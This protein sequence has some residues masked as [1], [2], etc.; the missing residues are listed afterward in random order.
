MGWLFGWMGR[1]LR[2]ILAMTSLALLLALIAL[3]GWAASLEDAASST[4]GPVQRAFRQ[5]GEP[6][7]NLLTEVDDFGRLES[8]NRALRSRIEQLEAENARLRE[9][10]IQVRGR[11]ELLQVQAES[12]AILLTA[13]VVTRDLTGLRTVVGLDRGTNDGVRVGQPVIASGGTLVGIVIDVRS[14]TSFVRLLTDPDSAVRVLH[15][16]SRIETVATGDAQGNLDVQIPWTAEVELGHMFVTSGLDG[17]LPQGL[18]VGRASAA[19]GTVQ[20]AFRHVRLQPLAPLEQLEQVLIQ[21]S[22]PP[23]DLS[24]GQEETALDAAA[25]GEVDTP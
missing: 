20:D 15:Q 4:L 5:A 24:F 21:L 14:R 18:P 22:I 16:Q 13:N 8:E 1:R 25:E 19:E 3:V 6:I 12:D 9:Q 23:P 7:S 11:Q 10:Q 2:W 17:L